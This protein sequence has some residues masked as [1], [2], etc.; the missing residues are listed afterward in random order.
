MQSDG[1]SPVTACGICWSLNP[2]PT[3]SDWHSTLMYQPDWYYSLME[4]LDSGTSYYARAYATNV[5]GTAYS[6]QSVFS[7]HFL[8]QISVLPAEL[9]SFGEALVGSV[10]PAAQMTIQGSILGDELTLSVGGNYGLSLSSRDGGRVFTQTI[11]I[12]AVDSLIAPTSVYVRFQP[13][14]GGNL[15]DLILC[16][17]KAWRTCSFRLWNWHGTADAQ[18]HSG[19]ILPAIPP[20]WRQ[21]PGRW[22]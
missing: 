20:R 1:L 8:P 18:H 16:Q 12:P 3:I 21:H 10:T 2:S 7:T 4:G 22:F 6:S 5:A 11:Q 9:P 17:A 13:Q 15:D 19:S 14:S